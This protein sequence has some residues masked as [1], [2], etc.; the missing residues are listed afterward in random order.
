VQETEKQLG[1]GFAFEEDKQILFSAYLG[2]IA[3]S[4]LSPEKE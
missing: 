1:C 2:S 4:H 3:Q